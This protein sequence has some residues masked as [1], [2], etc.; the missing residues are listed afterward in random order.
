MDKA[1]LTDTAS[2]LIDAG[3]VVFFIANYYYDNKSK[4]KYNLSNYIKNKA[5]KEFNNQN[6]NL[7]PKMDKERLEKIIISNNT[8]LEQLAIEHQINNNNNNPN[9]APTQEINLDKTPDKIKEIYNRL[10]E[11]V[12]TKLIN[13]ALAHFG[14]REINRELI[15]RKTITSKAGQCFKRKGIRDDIASEIDATGGIVKKNLKDQIKEIC[16]VFKKPFEKIIQEMKDNKVKFNFQD[17]FVRRQE[18]VNNL[19]KMPQQEGMQVV[20]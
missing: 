8:V 2:R 16:V 13:N 14:E 12:F 19:A 3:G 7:N 10:R 18:V 6:P 9:N 20:N 4:T 17:A 1:I 11:E 5:I 15:M